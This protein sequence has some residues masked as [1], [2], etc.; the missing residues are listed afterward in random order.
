MSVEE[1]FSKLISIG[2]CPICGGELEKGYVGAHDGVVWNK[3]KRK[4]F[5]LMLWRYSSFSSNVPALRC[6]H[7]GI[8]IFDYGYDVR[9]PRSFWRKCVRCSK[10]IPVASEECP[11]CGAK[12][13]EVS[14]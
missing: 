11:Y 9:T 7:C 2:K 10:P 5:G 1:E 6:E 14:I 13:K 8:I 3:D 12:Q 4:Y